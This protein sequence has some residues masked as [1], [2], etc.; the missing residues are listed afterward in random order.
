MLTALPLYGNGLSA[1]AL[2][3]GSDYP[4]RLG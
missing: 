1:I 2:Y 4:V 3:E